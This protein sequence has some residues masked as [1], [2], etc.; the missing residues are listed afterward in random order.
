MNVSVVI[1][2]TAGTEST[3]KT[4]SVDSTKTTT[5]NS[6]VAAQRPARLTKN[7][8]WFGRRKRIA[9]GSA[10]LCGLASASVLAYAELG[11]SVTVDTLSLQVVSG[12]AAS[13]SLFG[14]VSYFSMRAGERD[15]LGETATEEVALRIAVRF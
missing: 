14:G 12:F 13:A 7:A 3:A 5:T 9:G 10:I 2:S 11:Q 1:P 15:A 6:G 4:I 8:A